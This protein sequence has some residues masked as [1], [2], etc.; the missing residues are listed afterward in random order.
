MKK[1]QSILTFFLLLTGTSL[2][3]QK[4]SFKITSKDSI[5]K[6]ILTQLKFKKKLDSKTAIQ[7]QTDSVFQQ[8]KLKGYF[9]STVD[10]LIHKNDSISTLNLSL[11]KKIDSIHLQFPKQNKTI[12]KKL[13]ST[14]NKLSIH[15]SELSNILNTIKSYFKKEG[16]PFS[17]IKL[18]NIKLQK[19]NLFATIQ[20]NES[21]KR[22]LDKIIV[23]GYENFPRSYLDH[24]LRLK[25]GKTFDQEAIFK[26][27][28]NLKSLKFIKEIKRPEVLFNTDSTTL[29]L[30][31]EK[32]NVSSFDGLISLN[33]NP[34]NQDLLI[35]GNIFLD[36]VN[37][38]N[39]GEELNIKWN[40]NG[41]DSQNFNLNTKIP[42]LFNSSFSN[43]TSFEIHK[44]DST[45]LNSKFHTSLL[46]NINS[47]T[48]VG[49]F[50]ETETSTNTLVINQS[51][52]ENYSTTF[53][54]FNASYTIPKDHPLFK[55]KLRINLQYSLG[56][57]TT[58]NNKQTQSKLNIE[59]SYL[60]EI[61]PRNSVYLHNE[62]GILF[63]NNYLVNELYRIG[64]PNSIRGFE[65]QS[66]FTPKY[67][68][69]NL[70]YRF[71]TSK[72]SYLYS[73]TD[74]G[75]IQNTDKQTK[76]AFGYGI[77]YSF[78]L[79]KTIINIIANA[80]NS[81]FNST[82]KGFNLSLTLKNFF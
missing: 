9:Y 52:I 60:H 14:R 73:I 30:Y 78:T 39:T 38:L 1:T 63:S 28:R 2:F 22:I 58:N 56:S 20:I 6:T 81:N 55:T 53:G 71:L 47:S 49:L 76:N 33:S 19:N 11:G 26:T 61:N 79:N 67:S 57:R 80:G 51:S 18:S 41:N 69:F 12:Q 21:E 8:L 25:K 17:K 43:Q 45:F 34:D 44:Q 65:Q 23:K 74:F 75:I 70:E 24:F 37:I 35:S 40:A 27:S 59:S 42:Y 77:G 62:T 68:F 32:T 3:A 46:Y 7:T 64:G 54:G 66:I 36:L 16:K 13:F 48:E 15:F 72:N 5:E 29:Y 82:N 31:L 50:F 10:T 4:L